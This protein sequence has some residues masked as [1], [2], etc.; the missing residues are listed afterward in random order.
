MQIQ[1]IYV[2]FGVIFIAISFHLILDLEQPEVGPSPEES[3]SLSRP[4]ANSEQETD[5]LVQSD[6]EGEET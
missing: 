3:P 1:Y 6:E 2:N 5:E 4:P